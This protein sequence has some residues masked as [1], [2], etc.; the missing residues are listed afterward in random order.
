MDSEWGFAPFVVI[1][2]ATLVIGASIGGFLAF[3]K[4]EPQVFETV[5][6][7][8]NP[9]IPIEQTLLSETPTAAMSNGYR[10][11][12][13]SPSPSSTS[14]KAQN[15]MTF[16]VTVP[17]N[18][19]QDNTVWA[20]IWQAPRKMEKAGDNV[21]RLTLTE[22]ELVEASKSQVKPDAI[23]PYRYSRN[24]YDFHT[25]EYL[26]PTAEEPN[27][28]TNDYF[29]TKKG[30]EAIYNP[31][32]TVND[33]VKRWRWFSEK[34][35]PAQTTTL[36]PDRE[37]LPRIDGISFRSGQTIEDLY[38]PAFHDFFDTTARHMKRLGFT[39]VELDPPWQWIEENG[40]PK[41]RNKSASNPNYPDDETF[42]EE[43]RAYKKEGLH[44]LVAPQVCC[45]QLNTQDRKKEWWDAYFD[46]TERFLV[47]FA[48]LAEQGDADAFMYAVSSWDAYPASVDLEK[49]WRT[50]FG[51][52]KKV[53]SGEVGEMIWMLGPDVSASPQPIP[54]TAFVTWGDELDFFL[55]AM[56]FP[57]STKNNPTDDDL[58]EGAESVIEGVKKFYEKFKKPIII[59]NGY[60]NVKYSW[61]GQ[62]FYQIDSI[63][64]ISDPE[65]KLEE[66]KYE[67]DT[68][69]HARTVHAYFR[70]TAERPWIAGYFHFGYTHWEDPLSPWMS[71]RGKQAE[72]IWRKW[73]KLIYGS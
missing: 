70:A 57:L 58:E 34:G 24:G 7:V 64:S 47:Y 30:R 15:A 36:E 28:D 41:I 19:P 12:R 35:M 69:D 65:A 67:F 73:N 60:F 11:K 68:T 43:V 1:F 16:V 10:E 63:P 49:K 27:R 14:P 29:W 71:I 3:Q 66:S 23:V 13:P 48:K 33:T 46:E 25:A 53:F 5:P 20:Y 8:E 45:A 38:V 42:L 54:D 4:K 32:K 26:E 61:K 9:P 37:F 22:T 21:Y 59:R 2:I 39:W 6:S 44:V 40:L 62:S 72:D 17:E 31:G 55:V 52:I 18:T 51:S 56:E 50:I